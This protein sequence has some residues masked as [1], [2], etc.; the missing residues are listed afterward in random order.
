MK[1]PLPA[2]RCPRC[3]IVFSLRAAT[4]VSTLCEVFRA[5]G[6]S[7]RPLARCQLQVQ[8]VFSGAV[9]SARKTLPSKI[10]WWSVTV[11]ERSFGQPLRRMT[12]LLENL[13]IN[14]GA[15]RRMSLK[16]LAWKPSNRRRWAAFRQPDASPSMSLDTTKLVQIKI[17]CALQTMTS[18][19]LFLCVICMRRSVTNYCYQHV[20][21]TLR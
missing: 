13:Q 12:S 11:S 20:K 15:M 19:A 8:H 14:A 5:F 7:A 1:P 9:V 17:C 2:S 21:Y 18:G 3:Q 6:H 10:S 4:T 16:H